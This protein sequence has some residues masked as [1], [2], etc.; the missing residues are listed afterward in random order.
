MRHSS[1]FSGTHCAILCGVLFCL[2]LL[3]G[4]ATTTD[5][6]LVKDLPFVG[7]TES[8]A[9]YF[10]GIFRL[11]LGLAIT[12]AVLMLVVNGI[13]YMVSDAG[14]DKGKAKSGMTAAII[15][16]LIVF[17]SVL[18]LNTVNPEITKFNISETIRRT[19]EAV[20]KGQAASTMP[21]ADRTLWP[22][23]T[24]ERGL[25]GGTCTIKGR[26][27]F[28]SVNK[29]NCTYVGEKDCTSVYGLSGD[30]IASILNLSLKCGGVG[31]RGCDVQI[32]GGTEYWLHSTHGGGK[33]VD[34]S[35]R[36]DL[37]QYLG[38]IPDSCGD[39][40]KKD[41]ITFRWEDTTCPKE[42]NVTGDHWHVTFP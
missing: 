6:L 32:T 19:K 26:C 37:N 3:A 17:G 39:T 8:I 29:K 22:D 10:N 4:A 12:F 16:L 21:P 33:T 38:G 35:S 30:T 13:K 27:P 25:L 1:L 23:D 24:T 20:L 18:I 34:L 5:Y 14:G 36:A 7:K 41:G 28:V 11:G 15:G 42:W 40:V 9:S 31:S 2:P